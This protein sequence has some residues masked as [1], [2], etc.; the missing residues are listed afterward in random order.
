[1]NVRV[2][3]EFNQVFPKLDPQ[4]SKIIFTFNYLNWPFYLTQSSES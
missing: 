2:G 1:M 3:D 4:K